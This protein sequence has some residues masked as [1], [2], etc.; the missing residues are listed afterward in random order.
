MCDCMKIKLFGVATEESVLSKFGMAAKSG[1]PEM[2]VEINQFIKDKKQ[3]DIKIETG[4]I[5]YQGNT[6]TIMFAMVLYDD[7]SI[8]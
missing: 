5:T 6:H 7:S 4:Q 8:H 1:L 2:E 3:V